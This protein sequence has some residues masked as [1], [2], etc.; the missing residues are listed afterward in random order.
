MTRNNFLMRVFTR[1]SS[2]PSPPSGKRQK[3]WKFSLAVGRAGAAPT[4]I[5]E[6][7]TE[8][9]ACGPTGILEGGMA[10][11][12]G[13]GGKKADRSGASEADSRAPLFKS[14]AVDTFD[15]SGF[16][17]AARSERL[18]PSMQCLDELSDFAG[19]QSSPRETAAR[20]TYG[21]HSSASR[22]P[23]ANPPWRQQVCC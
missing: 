11:M 17:N 6:L 7:L 2:A 4:W 21:L 10:G 13:A 23:K 3:S 16:R 14:V 18:G 12:F 1:L 15:R 5:E 19:A 8:P 22:W 20:Y 9:S